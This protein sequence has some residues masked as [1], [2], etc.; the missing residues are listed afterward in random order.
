LNVPLVILDIQAPDELLR[1][2]IVRRAKN[3]S[4]ASEADLAVLDWQV[5]TREP[6]EATEPAVVV[7]LDGRQESAA[8]EKVA[9]QII[10][11]VEKAVRP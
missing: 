6:L 5:A 9:S 4:D 3:H 7:A 8:A 10:T 11:A 2:R 1:E